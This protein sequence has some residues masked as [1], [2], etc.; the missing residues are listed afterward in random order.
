MHYYAGSILCKV[1]RSDRGTN[2]IGVTDDL[3]I[4]VINVVDGTIKKSMYESGSVWKLNPFHSSHMGGDDKRWR[5]LDMLESSL[6]LVK[7]WLTSV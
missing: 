2:F 5:E 3:Y 4:E 1:Y 6:L 7:I